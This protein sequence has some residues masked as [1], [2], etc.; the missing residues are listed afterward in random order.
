MCGLAIFKE[1]LLLIYYDLEFS[2]MPD[3]LGSVVHILGIHEFK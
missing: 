2:H 1:M 3:R